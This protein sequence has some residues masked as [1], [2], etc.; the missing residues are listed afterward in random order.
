[1]NI[2]ARVTAITMGGQIITSKDTVDSLNPLFQSDC[3]EFNRISLKGKSEETFIYEVLRE[4]ADDV[5]RITTMIHF[6]NAVPLGLHVHLKYLDKALSLK[7]QSSVK[8]IG[9][10]A[11]CDF[12]INS[13]SVSRLHAKKEFRCGKFV[14]FDQ[15]TN[16]TI[17]KNSDGKE[18]YLRRKELPLIGYEMITLGLKTNQ[19][20][21]HQIY[22]SVWI[23]AKIQQNS[24][25][26]I[27]VETTSCFFYKESI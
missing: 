24:E 18:V 26:T 9:R 12:A 4:K 6:S 19:E 3:G 17:V 7:T 23:P 11:R 25:R 1:M 10:D 20:N 13:K 2:A 21:P 8:S 22:F 5:V 27:V 14:V 16:G 15:S